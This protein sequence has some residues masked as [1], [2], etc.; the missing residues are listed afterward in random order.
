MFTCERVAEKTKRC[1]IRFSETV[2]ADSDDACK[3]TCGPTPRHSLSPKTVRKTQIREFTSATPP[4][5]A[6][7]RCSP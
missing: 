7:A 3:K 1:T 2:R 4:V 5:R 6:A